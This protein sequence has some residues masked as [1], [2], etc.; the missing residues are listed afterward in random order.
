M[1][2]ISSFIQKQDLDV[3]AIPRVHHPQS[4][5]LKFMSKTLV[6]DLTCCGLQKQGEETADQDCTLHDGCQENSDCHT[7]YIYR[8]RKVKGHAEREEAGPTEGQ[9]VEGLGSVFHVLQELR[10]ATGTPR[11]LVLALI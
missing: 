4:E 11:V 6:E 5:I 1:I 7:D 2:A 9:L 8:S 10:H 3:C